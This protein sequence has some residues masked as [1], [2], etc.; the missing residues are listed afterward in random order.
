MANE[1]ISDDSQRHISSGEISE[2]TKCRKV[3]KPLLMI[4][5]MLL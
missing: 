1:H 3:K 4:S 2:K 5:G